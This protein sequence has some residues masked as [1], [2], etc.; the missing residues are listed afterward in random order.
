MP[1]S[2]TKMWPACQEEVWLS[3]SFCC[4]SSVCIELGTWWSWWCCSSWMAGG[5]SASASPVSYPLLLTVFGG[6]RGSWFRKVD[7]SPGAIFIRTGRDTEL[8]LR[9]E[10]ENMG[11]QSH[12]PRAHRRFLFFPP[13]KRWEEE[14][15]MCGIPST[16]AVWTRF[17]ASI[18]CLPHDHVSLR[19]QIGLP[20]GEWR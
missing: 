10:Q 18:L 20:S 11:D 15:Q 8:F 13:I 4:G 12:S 3:W 14:L 7:G 16:G 9:T 17:L 5:R 6:C 19:K 2:L 1:S